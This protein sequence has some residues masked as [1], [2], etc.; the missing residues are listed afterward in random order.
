MKVEMSLLKES[1][2]NLIPDNVVYSPKSGTKVH[3]NKQSSHMHSEVQVI[4]LAGGLAQRMKHSGA[5]HL[6]SVTQNKRVIDYTLQ[7]L[8]EMGVKNIVFSCVRYTA[9]SFKNYV[10]KE[11]PFCEYFQNAIF[12]VK[13]EAEGVMSAI[14]EPF[15]VHCDRSRPLIIIHGDEIL[16]VDLKKM[17]DFHL[18]QRHPITVYSTNHVQARN[19]MHLSVKN[20]KVL[21]VVHYNGDQKLIDAQKDQCNYTM[22]GLFIIQPS[23]I[24]TALQS[25]DSDIL[26]YNACKKGSFY[27]YTTDSLFLNVNTL[28]EVEEARRS[29]K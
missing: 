18:K 21:K 1:A 26:V 7:I 5:K 17:Y 16:F 15:K 3:I 8:M 25:A 27:T 10:L 9:D 11:S 14:R 24:E 22:T 23:Y 13:Q 6:I 28:N 29:L 12:Y 19:K 20:D 2:S 4:V